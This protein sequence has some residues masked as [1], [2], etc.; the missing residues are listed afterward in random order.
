MLAV[1]PN[2]YVQ[3]PDHYR[4]LGTELQVRV[5]RSMTMY[6]SVMIISIIMTSFSMRYEMNASLWPQ[7]QPC[8]SLL[9]EGGPG[10]DDHQG[11]KPC[12]RFGGSLVTIILF[13][14][15]LMFWSSILIFSPR[16]NPPG[17][18]TGL[19]ARTGSCATSLPWWPP[20][21]TT[22]RWWENCQSEFEQQ[23]NTQKWPP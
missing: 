18:A 13:M 15:F 3:M 20:S 12:Q 22:R 1:L 19:G 11:G 17:S 5:L 2:I 9:E 4:L 14:T 21:P 6:L 10:Q 16:Q 7:V 23:P 8:S